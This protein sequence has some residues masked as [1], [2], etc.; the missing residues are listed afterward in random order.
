MMVYA[1]TFIY[2]NQGTEKGFKENGINSRQ[3]SAQRSY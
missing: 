1:N 3:T 2:M